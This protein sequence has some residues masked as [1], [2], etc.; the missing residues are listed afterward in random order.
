MSM[1]AASWQVSWLLKCDVYKRFW[2]TGTGGDGGN[3]SGT[4]AVAIGVLG[5]QHV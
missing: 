1:F 4:V 3:T 5:G 2:C